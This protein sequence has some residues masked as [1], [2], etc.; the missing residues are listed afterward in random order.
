MSLIFI[1]MALGLGGV[2][3]YNH[4]RNPSGIENNIPAEPGEGE[5]GLPTP[6]L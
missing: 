3:F 6:E 4:Y 5:E 1:C 2:V